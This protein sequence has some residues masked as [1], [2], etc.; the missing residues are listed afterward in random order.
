MATLSTSKL[1]NPALR[2]FFGRI[3]AG[4]DSV[5]VLDVTSL[6]VGGTAVTATAA[7]LNI[8]DGVT[9]TA[10]ELNVLDGITAD[11]GELNK[12]DGAGA[13]VASGTAAALIADPTGGAVTDAEA[14]TAIASIIDALQAFGIVLN[15]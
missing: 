7:E 15:A 6:K 11:V 2:D 13:V 1:R 5:P 12:L 10:A 4:T 9:A 3:F 8:M 14:R